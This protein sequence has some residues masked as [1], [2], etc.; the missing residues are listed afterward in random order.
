ME[1]HLKDDITGAPCILCGAV[2]QR[3]SPAGTAGYQ[4]AAR[5][6]DSH[7]V[8]SLFRRREDEGE[9]EREGERAGERG[10][11]ERKLSAQLSR[12]WSKVHSGTFV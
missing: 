9:G 6:S 10:Q 11:E 5:A 8:I 4:S 3:G 12:G 2:R 7:Q 1:S